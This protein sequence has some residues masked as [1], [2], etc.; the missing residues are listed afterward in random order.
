MDTCSPV[1]S[2]KFIEHMFFQIPSSNMPAYISFHEEGEFVNVETFTVF[3]EGEE[4][5]HCGDFIS[6]L[7]VYMSLFYVFDFKYPTKL[8]KTLMFF[9][10]TLL[11]NKQR[12][13]SSALSER[14][15]EKH[16]LTVISR[17]NCHK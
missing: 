7:I 12:L 14:Q 4:I 11:G 10:K 16:V 13:A 1:S 3:S 17:L 6:A 2:N 15:S 8:V 9:D 5:C